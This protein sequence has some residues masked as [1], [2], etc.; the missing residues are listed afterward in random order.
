MLHKESVTQA[1][2]PKVSIIMPAY[3]GEKYIVESIHSIL[4]QTY[5]EWEL[6]LVDDGSIDQTGE[7][8]RDFGS[9]DE[10]VIYVFQQNG[11]QGQ[12][13]NTGIRMSRGEVIAF[14]DQDDLWLKEKLEF[15]LEAMKKANADVI[16]SDG[17]IFQDDD[18]TNE[19]TTCSAWFS[20][21]RGRFDGA[22]M[23]GYLLTLNRIPT[24]SAMVRRETMESVGLLEEDRRYQNCDDYD[25]WLKLAE[26]GA[27]FFGMSEKLVRY[28]LHSNQHSRNSIRMN[29]SEI[30]VLEKAWRLA[31]VQ[32]RIK[33]SRLSSLRREL[34]IALI[35][36]GQTDEAQKALREFRERGES[37]AFSLFERTLIMTLPNR[38]TRVCE[39]IKRVRDSFS[40]RIKEPLKNMRRRIIDSS[41]S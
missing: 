21:L 13:R 12:A 6:I 31:P 11:G 14:L 15:Q 20:A 17:F 24:L 22:T 39:Q 37:V 26:S 27:T 32:Q 4:A 34:I 38:Y 16:F 30:G 33:E 3:N 29:K 7:I 18:S 23:L 35:N 19:S 28:R 1:R 40:Y 2:R 25:L 36:D 5:R 8:A 9:R 41:S 10:R